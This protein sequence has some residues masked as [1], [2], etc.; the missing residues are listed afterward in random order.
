MFKKKKKNQTGSE[1][2]DVGKRHNLRISN[3]YGYYPED[4]DKVLLNY[5]K[6]L[7]SHETEIKNLETQLE[8]TKA[9]KK[10]IDDEFRKMKME[11]QFIDIP[12]I[13]PDESFSMVGKLRNINPEVGGL[14]DQVPEIAESVNHFEIVADESQEPQT[15]DDLISKPK[16]KKKDLHLKQKQIEKPV[17]KKQKKEFSILNEKGEFD[18]LQ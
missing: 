17:V 3:P 5:E 16:K 4:V 2:S 8:Q 18:I 6:L 7:S 1:M 11:M 9:E 12:D 10:M 15:F 13:S 14:P